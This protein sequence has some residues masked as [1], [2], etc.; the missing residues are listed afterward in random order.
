MGAPLSKCKECFVGPPSNYEPLT[1]SQEP[2]TQNSVQ[3]I[4]Q[5]NSPPSVPVELQESEFNSKELQVLCDEASSSFF[6]LLE[7]LDPARFTLNSD[8]DGCRVMTAD[9][10]RS[11]MLWAVFDMPCS[12]EAFIE[13]LKQIERRVEF[14]SNMQAAKV[15]CRIDENV[16]VSQ[17]TYKGVLAVKARDLII[18]SCYRNFKDSK[19][20]I[21]QSVQSAHYPEQPNCVRATLHLGGYHAQP[22]DAN[23]CRV[24]SVS[25][26]DLGGALP[27]M[28]VKKMSA[29]AFP[30]F[31]KNVR[32][33]MSRIT[34][35][36]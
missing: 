17:Q 8:K 22:I 31:I 23:S 26:T 10:D 6:A 34:T 2:Q 11:F 1:S 9:T 12:A 19:C 36:S 20:E 21:S 7:S 32:V 29:M 16:I 13:F 33:A 24:T 35:A 25:E 3:S 14:D 15:L 30:N 18:L 27:R 4:T 5:P 28:V